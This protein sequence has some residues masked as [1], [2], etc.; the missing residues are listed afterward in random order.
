MASFLSPVPFEAIDD[1]DVLLQTGYWGRFKSRFGWNAHAFLVNDELPLLALTRKI[2]FGFSLCYVPH[3]P[4][5]SSQ[6]NQNEYYL[7]SVSK[8]LQEH[9]PGGCAFIRYDLPWGVE[10]AQRRPSDLDAPF[11]RAPMDIQPPSTVVID[12]SLSEEEILAGMKSKSRYNIRL[13]ERKGVEVRSG[14]VE[15][16]PGWYKLYQETAA[17]DR[18]TIHS[19]GYYRTLFELAAEP[20]SGVRREARL[21]LAYVGEELLAGVIIMINGRRA[22]YLYGASSNEKRNYMPSHLLQWRAILLAKQMGC[23]LYDLFGIPFDDDAN[24]PMHGL[25][26]FKTGLGGTILNRPGSWDY[27]LSPGLYG[28]Y[29]GLEGMRRYYY[30][31]M[32]KRRSGAADQPTPSPST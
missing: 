9:L 19:E 28:V 15:E 20:S 27:A 4:L 8:H 25:Y 26:R 11:R 32:R 23:A 14:G 6:T 17:R 10:G 29:R 7:A 3:G 2:G 5:V 31:D 16:L 12:L 30:K 1:H 22:T 21:L 13:A 24:D 18:I